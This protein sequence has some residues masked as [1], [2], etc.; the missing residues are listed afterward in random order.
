RTAC[1]LL[2]P[3]DVKLIPSGRDLASAPREISQKSENCVVCEMRCPILPT[4]GARDAAG[5]HD[6]G[7]RNDWLVEGLRLR[8]RTVRARFGG[9]PRGG[10][11]LPGPQRRRQVDNHAPAAGAD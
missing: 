6:G 5:E 1:S 2:R 10:V 9:P 3:A 4:V 7:H 11:R 8:T